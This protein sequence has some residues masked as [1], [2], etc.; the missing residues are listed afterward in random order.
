MTDTTLTLEYVRTY[1]MFEPAFTYN[2]NDLTANT[3]IG[4]VARNEGNRRKWWAS[5]KTWAGGGDLV[6]TFTTRH[7]AA[8]ALQHIHNGTA[9]AETYGGYLKEEAN[10]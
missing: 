4:S 1:S 6:Q 10:V 5:N 7:E 9:T 8:R 3:R 2:V